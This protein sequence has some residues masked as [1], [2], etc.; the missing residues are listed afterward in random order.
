MRKVVIDL[1][2]QGLEDVSGGHGQG[3]AW[4]VETSDIEAINKSR[5]SRLQHS[6]VLLHVHTHVV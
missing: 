2:H 5:N 6:K 4:Q 3:G 1:L